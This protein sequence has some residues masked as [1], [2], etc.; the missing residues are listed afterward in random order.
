M[1][2]YNMEQHYFFGYVSAVVLHVYEKH[3]ICCSILCGKKP[4]RSYFML[5]NLT[6]RLGLLIM[7]C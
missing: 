4:G 1:C 3:L 6:M 5:N 7:C 2:I